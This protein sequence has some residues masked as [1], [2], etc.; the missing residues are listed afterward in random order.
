MDASVRRQRINILQERFPKITSEA[1]HLP[2]VKSK[3]R[4]QIVLR[5]WQDLN[6]HEV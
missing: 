6:P 2:L 5:L 4:D 1:G 3:P